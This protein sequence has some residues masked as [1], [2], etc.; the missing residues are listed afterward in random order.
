MRI[1]QDEAGKVS[2]VVERVK[3]G[4]KQRFEGLEALSELIAEMLGKEEE[5]TQP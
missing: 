4:E 5:S 2:G 1:L 3:T